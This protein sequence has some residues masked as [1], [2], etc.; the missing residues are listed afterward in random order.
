MLDVYVWSA[1]RHQVTSSPRMQS[2][3]C[4]VAAQL[5]MAAITPVLDHGKLH[6]GT[7]RF[8]VLKIMIKIAIC[9]GLIR[10]MKPG[11]LWKR[12]MKIRLKYLFLF[13]NIVGYTLAVVA[14]PCSKFLLKS[15]LA[16]G[17]IRATKPGLLWK[18]TTKSCLK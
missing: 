6:V 14:L 12:T 1:D 15:Q 13:W 4:V 5:H 16:T 10:G 8:S 7:G 17:L 9:H 11:L 2:D 18:R 3:V